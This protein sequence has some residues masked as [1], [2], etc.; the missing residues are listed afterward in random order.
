MQ[1]TCPKCGYT[2]KPTD[3][4]PDYEC[5]KCGVIYAKVMQ[6]ANTQTRG[7]TNPEQMSAFPPN[8]QTTPATRAAGRHKQLVAAA[9]AVGLLVGYFAGREHIKYELRSAF[10]DAAAGFSKSLGTALGGGDS[11]KSEDREPP[12]KVK[13]TFPI[14]ATLTNKGWFEGEYGRNAITFTVTFANTTGKNVRAFD[15]TLVFTDLLGNEILGANLA[16][17]DPVSSG[18]SIEWKGKLDYNQFIAKHESL[19]NADIQNTRVN[20]LL[21]HVLFEDGEVKDF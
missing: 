3:T 9:F 10:Q 14:T 11:K 17:N 7:E 2:R 1:I 12:K 8:A 20:F 18:Q 21:K 13:Q 6:R 4:A 15:G 19:R 16:V 5:P